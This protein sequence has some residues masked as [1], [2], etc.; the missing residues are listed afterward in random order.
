MIPER[1]EI[2][3]I[4]GDLLAFYAATSWMMG[5]KVKKVMENILYECNIRMG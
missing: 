2:I 1:A 4:W 3:N 5:R